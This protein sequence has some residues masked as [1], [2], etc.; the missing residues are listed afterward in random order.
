M[1]NCAVIHGGVAVAGRMKI[2]LLLSSTASFASSSTAFIFSSFNRFFLFFFLPSPSPFPFPSSS[3]PSSH[4]P[5]P[6]LPSLVPFHSP[7]AS[8]TRPGPP[9][10]AGVRQVRRR[11][12]PGPRRVPPPPPAA[13]ARRRH[14]LPG[15]MHAAEAGPPR[16]GGRAGPRPEGPPR[17]RRPAAV[18][19]V[20]RDESRGGVHLVVGRPGPAAAAAAAAAAAGRRGGEAEP[21]GDVAGAMGRVGGVVGAG[22]RDG[23]G[24]VPKWTT[25]AQ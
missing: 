7:T 8:P 18:R 3:S 12:R 6:S 5:P 1:Q 13:A 14:Q 19:G 9:G 15:P 10:A 20:L 25:G 17:R 16:A 21:H 11:V 2:D 23:G 22:P 4:P 24:G